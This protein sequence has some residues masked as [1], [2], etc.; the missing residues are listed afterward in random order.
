MISNRFCAFS[1][2][3]STLA[4]TGALILL[5]ASPP[6]A[7]TAGL[8]LTEDFSTTDLRDD[9]LTSADWSTEEQAVFL[10]WSTR[11]Q[12][13]RYSATGI[14][15]GSEADFTRSVVLGDVNGD[16]HLDL[17]AGNDG[18]TNKLYLND[19]SGGFPATGIA[20][21]IEKEP[22]LGLALGDVDND[23]DLDLVAGNTVAI[24]NKLYRNV[25]YLSTGTVVSTTVNTGG[26]VAGVVLTT[27]SSV[28]TP[29][30]RQH[31]YRLFRI[32]QRRSEM[33]PDVSG[34]RIPVSD[35][36]CRPALESRAGHV[37]A[38][39]I[40]GSFATVA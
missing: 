2:S 11:H 29:H 8:P 1:L 19:G 35:Q 9:A 32:Q 4:L 33:V 28:N 40:T 3:F 6:P 16:G 26:P 38:R 18:E 14:A 25:N 22:A 21:G 5:A 27:V 23:G 36:R 10:A 34:H 17:I 20:V 13:P 7:A 12:L 37:V 24:T 31:R 39:A 15:V 30:H